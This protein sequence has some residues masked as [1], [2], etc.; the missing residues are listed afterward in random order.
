MPS[1]S[2]LSHSATF[3]F[4]LSEHLTTSPADTTTSWRFSAA[5]AGAAL[6]AALGSG[7]TIAC[8]LGAAA[9]AAALVSPGTLGPTWKPAMRGQAMPTTNPTAPTMPTRDHAGRSSA[10]RGMSTT[11]V[12]AR[13]FSGTTVD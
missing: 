12:R 10:G 8:P 1:K 6:G 7:G 4:F 3:L 13:G 9:S 11:G 5:A 2:I